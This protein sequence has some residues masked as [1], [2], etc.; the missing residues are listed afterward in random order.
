MDFDDPLKPYETPLSW[1]PDHVMTR[2]VWAFE[3]LDRVRAK[4]GPTGYGSGWPRYV[5]EWSDLLAQEEPVP[6]ETVSQGEERRRGER[7]PITLPPSSHE[8]SLMDEALAWPA[9]YLKVERGDDMCLGTWAFRRSRGG[10]TGEGLAMGA[11]WD[12]TTV[13]RGLARDRVAVR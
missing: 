11:Y 2:M 10:R 13:A 7:R 12:A 8:V 9:R 4:V 3:T 1:T 5:H 6:G